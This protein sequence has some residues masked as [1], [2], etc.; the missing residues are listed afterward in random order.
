MIIDGLSEH[1][2]LISRDHVFDVNISILS[3]MFLKN[4][5][6]LLNQLWEIL[7]LSLRII[8]FISNIY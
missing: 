8:N 6:R 2:T 4:L 3:T 7:I 5:Q 1:A